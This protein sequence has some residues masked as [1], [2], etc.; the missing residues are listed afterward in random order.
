MTAIY[1]L[2][3]GE[4]ISQRD[5]NEI[6]F[7]FREHPIMRA[8]LQTLQE[9]AFSCLAESMTATAAEKQGVANLMMGGF[10]QISKVA[11]FLAE[12]SVTEPAMME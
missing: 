5:R 11:V 6:F 12:K 3:T 2:D 8:V 4:P 9:E 1:K 7:N 10:M